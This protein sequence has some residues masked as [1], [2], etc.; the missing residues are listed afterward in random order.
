VQQLRLPAL[1]D[2]ARPLVDLRPYDFVVGQTGERRAF[3]RDPRFRA[4]L[5]QLFAVDL[6]FFRQCV[7][8]C[9]QVQPSLNLASPGLPAGCAFVD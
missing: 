8:S 6:Q 9:G 4:D 1:K 7:N 2:R 3:V 5:D